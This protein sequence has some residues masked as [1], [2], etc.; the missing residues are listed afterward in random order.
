MQSNYKYTFCT[1]APSA[2]IQI[3]GMYKHISHQN[4]MNLII[5]KQKY[6]HIKT[7][8]FSTLSTKINAPCYSQSK[9]M[10]G[11]G[12]FSHQIRFFVSKERGNRQSL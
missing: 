9:Y 8:T 5:K 7:N 10:L 1:T 12:S 3:T 6:K 4:K 11:G 2:F